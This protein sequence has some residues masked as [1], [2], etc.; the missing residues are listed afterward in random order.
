MTTHDENPVSL[1]PAQDGPIAHSQ[2][3]LDRL[4]PF[5]LSSRHALY[6]QSEELPRT[7]FGAEHALV[8]AIRSVGFGVRPSPDTRAARTRQLPNLELRYIFWAFP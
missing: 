4:Q 7:A 6:V 1:I 5:S 8:R 3:L 2:Q